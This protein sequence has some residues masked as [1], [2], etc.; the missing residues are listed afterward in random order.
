MKT[1]LRVLVLLAIVGI[2]VPNLELPIPTRG[3][4]GVNI[5]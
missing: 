2:S 3:V 5:G 4:P 1:I